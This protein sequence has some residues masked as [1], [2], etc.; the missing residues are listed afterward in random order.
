V[1]DQAVDQLGLEAGE[2]SLLAL[3]DRDLGARP[4]GDVRQLE[5]DEAPAEE[6]D[7]ARQLGQHE[8]VVARRQELGARQVEQRRHR[9]GRDQDLVRGRAPA[10]G[11]DRVERDEPRGPV[12]DLD[13]R[14]LQGLLR[15]VGERVDEAVLEGDQLAPRDA[16]LRVAP[17][18]ALRAARRVEQLRGVDQD[19]LRVA[20]AQRAGAA[21]LAALG[22]GDALSGARAALGD[23]RAGHAGPEHDAIEGYLFH[24][25]LRRLVG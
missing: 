4:A 13:S 7:A 23:L 17:E 10:V 3:V 20:A 1:R 2:G 21:D 14:L 9:A 25:L 16:R 11:G 6:Q 24:A 15:R 8:E 19:L 22:D 5:G 18:R 12:Q